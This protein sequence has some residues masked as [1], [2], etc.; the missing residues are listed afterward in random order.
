MRR[1]QNDFRICLVSPQVPGSKSDKGAP[2]IPRRKLLF[3]AIVT[4]PTLGAILTDRFIPEKDNKS[5]DMSPTPTVEV[6]PITL[7]YNPNSSQP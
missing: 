2:R 3:A 5:P 7:F 6:T 1:G 4:I